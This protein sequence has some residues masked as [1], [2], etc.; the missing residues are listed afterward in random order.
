MKFLDKEQRQ[1]IGFTFVMDQLEAMTPY[2]AEEK[3][4][5]KPFK[6]AHKDKLL[7]ELDDTEKV[8]EGIKGKKQL[9]SE[10]ERIFCKLKDIKSSIKRCKH[11]EVLDDI[12]LYEIKYFSL[13]N[14]EL[15][16][17]FDSLDLQIENI[18]L[19]SLEEAILLLD[20]EGKK[21]PTF[22]IY[23]QYSERLK[24]IREEKTKLEHAILK[25]EDEDTITMLKQQRLDVVILEE[26]EELKVRRDLS[27]KL[28][29]YIHY[30]EQNMESIGKLDFLM[31][32]AKLAV[33]YNA[34]K[35][36]I[37]KKMELS[38]KNA[39]NPEIEEVLKSREKTFTPV[40]IDLVSGTTVITGANMGG[41]S[42][43]LKTIVLNL[44]LGQMGL[45]VFAKEAKLPVL[46]FVY[47]VS[48]DMQN[49]SKGLSTFG[50][51]IIKLKEVIDCVK[52]EKG[53][54]ALD[55]FARGTNPKEG[56]YLV[57]SLSKYLAKYDSISLISTHYDGVVEEDMIHYQVVGLKNVNFEALKYKI[58]LN[59]KHSVEL[60]QENMEYRLERVSKDSEVPKDALNISILLG[61]D[62]ELINIAKGFY[63]DKE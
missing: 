23:D 50:A 20:P 11:N 3:K 8:I 30:F 58:D 56:F 39:V 28:S 53:F 36:E 9:Y 41:K 2:G 59:K 55:E 14:E 18:R 61:L 25:E 51:E 5:I 44:L 40:S 15:L 12:E 7:K 38:L 45:Y 27:E 6:I 63:A 34:V 52:S 31:A 57:K 62:E 48:D 17:V 47:F 54:L 32:K 10:V 49:I 35:P 33:K 26:E 37:S 16:E 21:I 43:T 13:L 46:D 4:D 1:Q 29:D 60:I 42:V 19:N 24:E 22:Y